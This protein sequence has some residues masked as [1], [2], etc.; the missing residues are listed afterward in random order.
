MGPRLGRLE[1]ACFR[2]VL[3]QGHPLRLYCYEPPE[4]VPDGVEIEDA[5]TIL[6]RSEVVRYRNGSV[7]LFS[8]RF[9]YELLRR[10]AGTW[11]D[12]DVYLIRPLDGTRHYLVGEEAPGK[13]GTAILRIPPTS[14]LL[15]RLLEPFAERRVPDWLPWR[16]AG[17]AAH[18][19]LLLTGRTGIETMPWA[20]TGPHALTAL[21][22]PLLADIDPLPPRL[23]YP[24]P[25]QDAGWIARP[26][27]RLD[28]VIANDTIAIHLWNELVKHLKDRPA[29]PGS[30]LFRLQQEGR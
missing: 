7:A 5:A 22:R 8:N 28:D 21:A 1:R 13:L 10:A 16:W 9:R 3:R 19:R 26:D 12:S 24:I 6:P 18:L 25:W 17:L 11:I 20:T 14:P 23:L 29:A 15:D 27:R 30:F 4:G 2:S